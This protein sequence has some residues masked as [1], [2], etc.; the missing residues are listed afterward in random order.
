MRLAAYRPDDRSLVDASMTYFEG[1]QV[2][3][4]PRVVELFAPSV[5]ALPKLS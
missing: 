4:W 2:G 1:E 3:G 5:R